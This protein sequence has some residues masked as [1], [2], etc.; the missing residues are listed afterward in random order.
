MKKYIKNNKLATVGHGWAEI[1][2]KIPIY[3]TL[4]EEQILEGVEAEIIGYDTVV[5]KVL[6]PTEQML[7]DSGYVE[8]IPEKTLE[9]IKADKI[10]EIEAYDKSSNVN[11][12]YYQGVAMWIERNDRMSLM[13]SISIEK[14]AGATETTLNLNGV[15]VV[16][17]IDTAILMLS[18]LELYAKPCWLNT[19]KHIANVNALTEIEE[20]EAYD[21]TV[22]YPDKL[23]F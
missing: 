19:S 18:A 1:E 14:A 23:N 13:H 15:D 10:A 20:V 9:Q 12:F 7:I 3:E 8:Y 2:F 6:N 4:T 21:Y 5:R 22:G 16:L 17:A 11:E